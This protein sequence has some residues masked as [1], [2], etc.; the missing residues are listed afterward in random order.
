MYQQRAFVLGQVVLRAPRLGQIPGWGPGSALAIMPGTATGPATTGQGSTPV[1]WGTT[2]AP[3]A[4]A[5]SRKPSLADIAMMGGIAAAAAAA[6][7]GLLS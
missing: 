2:P 1:E 3:F 6:V 4:V 5:P 7:Y